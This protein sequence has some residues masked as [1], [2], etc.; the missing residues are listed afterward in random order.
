M[1]GA[2]TTRRPF[3]LLAAAAFALT[4]LTLAACSSGDG[5]PSASTPSGDKPFAGQTLT[6]QNWQGYGTDLDWV[7]KEFED[8]TGATVVHDYKQ[9]DQAALQ[10]LQ[11]G[12]VGKIDVAMV[13]NAYIQPAI[14]AGVIVPLDVS[15]LTHYDE[16]S[17]ELRETESLSR[18]GQVY[19]APWE[20]G[21]TTLSYATEAVS[22]PV[23]SWDDLW[24][25]TYAGKVAFY[26]DPQTAVL[27]AAFY[28]GQDPANPNLD[29]VENALQQLRPNIKTY[30]SQAN[31]WTRAF[32]GGQVVIG[33]AWSSLPAQMGEPQVDLVVPDAG[34]V[35]WL[36]S[37]SL[38]KDSPHPD[39]A[40]EWINFMTSK[41]F[42]D[43]FS[44]DKSRQAAGPANR[45]VLDS[46]PPETLRL[47]GA[48][49]A[50]LPN[51]QIVDV[52]P[53]QLKEWTRLWERV[54]VGG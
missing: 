17:Q 18:D 38:V 4:S 12:G 6:V 13:N 5:S 27:T 8:A 50:W 34:T 33:N 16:L 1:H 46:L 48:D 39:L 20:W 32:S 2:Q 35:G 3:R 42:Q 25:S 41:G 26:D 47:L 40:Y 10:V 28:L 23:T 9:S 11:S 52:S 14:D 7:V 45:V 43:R 15:R 19:G 36:D 24:G 53:E 29:D 31:D 44:K 51:L 49:P 30:W 21:V 54:K 22:S 37:W